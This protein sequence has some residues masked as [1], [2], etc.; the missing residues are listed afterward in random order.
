VKELL[1]PCRRTRWARNLLSPVSSDV[2]HWAENWAGCYISTGAAIIAGL[3]LGFI[4]VPTGECSRNIL[5]GVHFDDV[6]ARM[7]ERG[8]YIARDHVTATRI[9][10]PQPEPEIDPAF[11]AKWAKEN[12]I[13]VADNG[14]G[15]Q[16]ES[17]FPVEGHVGDGDPFAVKAAPHPFWAQWA[18]ENRI[19]SDA[20]EIEER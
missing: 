15:G 4:C 12:G 10:P 7:A 13:A 16:L 20:D 14:D 8:W 5:I 2:K 19:D 17:N 3:E 6:S 11:W 9:K 18:K 1:G